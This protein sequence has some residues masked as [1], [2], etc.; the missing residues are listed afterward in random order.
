MRDLTG[1]GLN[2]NFRS[3]ADRR[4]LLHLHCK[5]IVLL[6]EGPSSEKCETQVIS[7][8]PLQRRFPQAEKIMIE[9]TVYSLTQ[10]ESV[11]LSPRTAYPWTL[12][13]NSQNP[14]QFYGTYE[15]LVQQNLTFNDA[16]EGT[17]EGFTANTEEFN[18]L[19]SAQVY[20]SESCQKV[21]H[22]LPAEKSWV[23][24]NRPWI[25]TAGAVALGVL[26][27]SMK[28]KKMVINTN[29]AQ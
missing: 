12:L 26:V 1:K 16:V 15:Q 10:E 14:V 6:N 17:C 23:E 4:D 22:S 27:Y 2:G 25:Y 28:D 8:A 11:P 18:A 13:S 29:G 24:K 20:F 19:S 3:V 5:S 9:T 21:S 7:I